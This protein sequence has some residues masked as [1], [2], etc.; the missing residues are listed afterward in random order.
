M[1]WEWTTWTLC[2]AWAGTEYI[3]LKNFTSQAAKR[4]LKKL[5]LHILLFITIVSSCNKVLALHCIIHTLPQLLRICT[6]GKYFTETIHTSI[7]KCPGLQL[8]SF[9]YFLFSFVVV[10][11]F[12]FMCFI[13]EEL[14]K[15]GKRDS[16][17]TGIS[18][19]YMFWRVREVVLQAGGGGG[20]VL[21][22]I[23][24]FSNKCQE[25]YLLIS[26]TQLGNQTQP[27]S[28]RIPDIRQ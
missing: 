20:G 11:L 23:R 21:N 17:S 2:Y 27:H 18:T 25:L 3:S 4:F 5:F 15:V 6:L 16:S 10:I 22:Y 9:F 24:F 7:S 14:L 19:P 12:H 13:T 8:K 26:F 1:Y 28:M